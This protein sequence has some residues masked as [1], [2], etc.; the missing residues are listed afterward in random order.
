MSH[1][2]KHGLPKMKIQV[3]A[4]YTPTAF[5][6]KPNAFKIYALPFQNPQSTH[7]T[8]DIPI[9]DIGDDVP[10]VTTGVMTRSLSGVEGERAG[11]DTTRLATQVCRRRVEAGLGGHEAGV[12]GDD[13]GVKNAS[14]PTLKRGRMT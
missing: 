10:D 5:K 8:S 6:I 11:N 2:L 1:V 7:T 13:E 12:M 9:K 3:F 4:K 14:H